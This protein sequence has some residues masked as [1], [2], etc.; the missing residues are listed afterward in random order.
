MTFR[1]SCQNRPNFS[2][3][4]QYLLWTIGLLCPTRNQGLP[5]QGHFPQQTSVTPP[6]LLPPPPHSPHRINCSRRLLYGQ[7]PDVTAHT[8]VCISCVATLLS[9]PS[10]SLFEMY[11]FV[12]LGT[13]ESHRRPLHHCSLLWV[14]Y[15]VTIMTYGLSLCGRWSGADRIS[16]QNQLFH[17]DFCASWIF[18]LLGTALPD[19]AV[20]PASLMS[21]KMAEHFIALTDEDWQAFVCHN[22]RLKQEFL[23]HAVKTQKQVG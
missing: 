4:L 19:V 2:R 22:K 1:I 9:Q 13:S 11:P 18:S 12:A 5:L 16:E 7:V 21:L 8:R 14:V 20:W 3:S 6:L 10:T 15:K 17:W 23:F